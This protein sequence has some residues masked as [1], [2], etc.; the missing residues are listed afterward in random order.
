MSETTLGVESLSSELG[1]SRVHLY[2]KIKALTNL[3]AI[4]F[5]RNIRLKRAEAL[6]RDK[7][8]NIN[9]ISLM[10]G[11]E[12]ADYFRACFKRTYGMTPR[13]FAENAGI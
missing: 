11:F 6:L 1:L 7:K 12:D 13:E 5:I 2:R 4:E 10:V 3:S 9:E 8:M